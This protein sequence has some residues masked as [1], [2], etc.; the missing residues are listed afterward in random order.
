MTSQYSH[1]RE[2]ID[3]VLTRSSRAAGTRKE[4]KK[5]QDSGIRIGLRSNSSLSGERL[6]LSPMSSYTVVAVSNGY[7]CC[8]LSQVITEPFVLMGR[9]KDGRRPAGS[10]GAR[11]RVMAFQSFVI[12]GGRCRSAQCPTIAEV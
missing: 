9:T 7:D 6:A 8:G 5:K 4:G 11:N 1:V 10:D 12:V 2:K 3:G